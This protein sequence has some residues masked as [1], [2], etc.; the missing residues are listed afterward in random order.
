MKVYLDQAVSLTGLDKI[1]SHPSLN[2]VEQKAKTKPSY[3]VL[4]LSIVL[5]LLLA[6][7]SFDTLVL[8]T[9]GYVVPAYFTF[10]SM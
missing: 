10:L 8:G 1:D 6:V 7:F 9:V 2:W 4:G 5:L 3:I